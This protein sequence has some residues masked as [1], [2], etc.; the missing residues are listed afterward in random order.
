MKKWNKWYKENKQ[1]CLKTFGEWI[2]RFQIGDMDLETYCRYQYFLY[3]YNEKLSKDY[4][5]WDA[6]GVCP[7]DLFKREE[8]FK[9]SLFALF[10]EESINDDGSIKEFTARA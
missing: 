5:T 6:D 7:K 3:L 1:R 9:L 4:N 2:K 10:E 8:D